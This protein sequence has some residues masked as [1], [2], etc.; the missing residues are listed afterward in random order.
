MY[1]YFKL[2]N[3]RFHSI[4]CHI[5]NKES[6]KS[7]F[8]ILGLDN[9]FL[10]QRQSLDTLLTAVWN[11]KTVGHNSGFHLTEIRLSTE[12]LYIIQKCLFI[13]SSTFL[14]KIRL[15]FC[16]CCFPCL[17]FWW[18]FVFVVVFGVGLRI[19]ES[20]LRT[21]MVFHL[22]ASLSLFHSL[23]RYSNENTPYVTFHYLSKS[24]E[25]LLYASHCSQDFE[26]SKYSQIF[27]F[28]VVYSLIYKLKLEFCSLGIPK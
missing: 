9:H 25:C 23:H 11:I 27:I 13:L 19:K 22:T 12:M 3:L 15:M 5:Y 26:Y 17:S 4:T 7:F 28:S 18:W 2:M 20:I 16:N 8:Q 10:F 1:C 14:C 6:V 21:W 24:L